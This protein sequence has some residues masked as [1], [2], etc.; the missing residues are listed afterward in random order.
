MK[1]KRLEFSKKICIFSSILFVLACVISIY[2]NVTGNGTELA[3]YLIPT[4]G[5]LVS[6]SFGFY[7]NKAKAENLAKQRL[8]TVLIKNVL[9]GILPEDVYE[10]LC[11]ELDNM[12]AALQEKIEDMYRN[13]V[14]EEV[15][16]T[17]EV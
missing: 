8:R 6:V 9:Q 7:F 1:K 10:E 2:L 15:E 3:M 16:P 5:G 11:V 17:K 13:S 12:D 14:D 4:T